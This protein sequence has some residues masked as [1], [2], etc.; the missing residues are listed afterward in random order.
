MTGELKFLQKTRLFVHSFPNSDPSV[1]AQHLLLAT[2]QQI[3]AK[4]ARQK[5][6]SICGPYILYSKK[7]YCTWYKLLTKLAAFATLDFIYN[8]FLPPH[9]L[10]LFS[11]QIIV[12]N[13]QCNRVI[14]RQS[15]IE[16][17]VTK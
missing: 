2:K 17:M 13:A 1:D 4:D 11:S 14:I 8:R 5:M 7:V 12:C 6:T 3:A 16:I 9:T 15:E 10:I